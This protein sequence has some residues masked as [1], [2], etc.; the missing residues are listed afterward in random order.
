MTTAPPLRS[1]SLAA[2]TFAFTPSARVPMRGRD[3]T[4]RERER[5]GVEEGRRRS[6]LGSR[7]KSTR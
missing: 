7:T 5:E 3:I 2:R 6:F 4:E 1:A